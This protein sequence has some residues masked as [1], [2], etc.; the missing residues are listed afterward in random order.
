M[1][2]SVVTINELPELPEV[3]VLYYSNMHIHMHMHK[4]GDVNKNRLAVRLEQ[5]NQA[6]NLTTNFFHFRRSSV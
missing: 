1:E 6:I 4:P 3:A 2:S 5:T